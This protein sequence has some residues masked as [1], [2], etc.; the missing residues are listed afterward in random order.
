[1]APAT[2]AA[3]AKEA[4]G[5]EDASQTIVYNINNTANGF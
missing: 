2:P 5:G 1:V 4:K 3:P